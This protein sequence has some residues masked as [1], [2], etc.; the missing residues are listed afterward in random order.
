MVVQRKWETISPIVVNIM[1]ILSSISDFIKVWFLKQHYEDTHVRSGLPQS[2]R[3]SAQGQT[4]TLLD[5]VLHAASPSF[6]VKPKTQPKIPAVPG[7]L[8]LNT[9]LSAPVSRGG[10]QVNTELP[11]PLSHGCRGQS[12]AKPCQV[13]LLQHFHCSARFRWAVFVFKLVFLRDQRSRTI[14]C[15]NWLHSMAS[16]TIINAS[17]FTHNHR[18][19]TFGAT[20][21]STIF[22]ECLLR[23]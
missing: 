6:T 4:Q 23:E 5:V 18:A 21:Y 11:C 12:G 10:Q 9:L 14:K 2:V 8:S 20:V 16:T 1:V 15:N 22:L 3:L 7:S 19:T 13:K 17:Y